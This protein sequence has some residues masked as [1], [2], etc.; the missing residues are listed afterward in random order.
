MCTFPVVP[1]RDQPPGLGTGPLV[2]G[3][4]GHPM[5][6]SRVIQA[7]GE[8]R[9]AAE[10][11]CGGFSTGGDHGLGGRMKGHGACGWGSGYGG[12]RA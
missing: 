2:P 5:T 11:H 12:E 3:F 4:D 7:R 9:W 10:V 1:H 6:C 8:L